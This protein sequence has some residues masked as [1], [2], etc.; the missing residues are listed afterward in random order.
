MDFTSVRP[1]HGVRY[2]SQVTLAP[3]CSNPT[4]NDFFHIPVY[5]C[6]S[7]S[8]SEINQLRCPELRAWCMDND[9]KY[10]NSC[11]TRWLVI[12]NSFF[13]FIDSSELP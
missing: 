10:I 4:R 9:M 7:V 1:C 11:T 3:L 6:N 8:G 2:N 12:G 5:K 13:K